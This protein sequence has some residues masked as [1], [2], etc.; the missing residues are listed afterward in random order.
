[1]QD[2]WYS[3]KRDLFKW[4]CLIDLAR[5]EKIINILQV[6][7][8]R[9]GKKPEFKFD[10]KLLPV[11]N[12]VWNHFRNPSAITKLGEDCKLKISVITNPFSD[13]EREEYI[14]SV[15][16]R[17][18][19]ITSPRIIFL[20]PDTGIEPTKADAK[21]VKSDEIKLIWNS[22]TSQDWLLFYQHARHTK[23]WV[24]ETQ[25]SFSK[26]CDNAPVKF[27]EGFQVAHDVV[28]FGAKK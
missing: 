13:G 14:K 26:A 24:S 1:M 19:Q 16:K 25:L 12:E 17:I 2:I 10:G 8:L 21:H 23:E 18:S 15:V 9:Y 22:L 5:R 28:L 20:D 6:A 11:P 7:F 3:D 4:G 27:F